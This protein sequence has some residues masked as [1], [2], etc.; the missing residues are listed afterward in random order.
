MF[1]VNVASY[2]CATVLSLL[3]FAV[4]ALLGM[5]FGLFRQLKESYLFSGMINSVQSCFVDVV[6]CAIIQLKNVCTLARK[7]S[8]RLDTPDSTR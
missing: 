7:G 5:R 2:I 6:L 3:G 4:C 1:I 8:S